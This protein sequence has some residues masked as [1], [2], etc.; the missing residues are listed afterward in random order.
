MK[1]TLDTADTLI[2]SLFMDS[3]RAAITGVL[4][5][6]DGEVEQD[7]IERSSTPWEALESALD[8]AVA[9]GVAHV[10]ILTNSASLVKALSKPFPAP[11]GGSSQRVWLGGKD[12]HYVSGN[13]GNPSQW[14]VLREL[15]FRWAGHWRIMQVDNLPV[16]QRLFNQS[17][18]K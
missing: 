11:A 8:D 5:R 12:G 3:Q 17:S 16:A 6:C 4:R 18:S 1:P 15:G 10:L 7:I 14:N 2:L 13:L 9:I